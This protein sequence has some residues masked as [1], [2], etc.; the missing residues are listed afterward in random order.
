MNLL[1]VCSAKQKTAWSF[2]CK[3][4]LSWAW[5]RMDW[6]KEPKKLSNTSILGLSVL[7]A[8]IRPNEFNIGEM[9]DAMA[10]GAIGGAALGMIG[11]A[12]NVNTY[13]KQRNWLPGAIKIP[14]MPSPGV[15]GVP[16][17]TVAAPPDKTSVNL[18][19]AVAEEL[20]MNVRFFR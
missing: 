16:E 18:V 4:F 8:V 20:G 7:W 2:R 10:Q 15:P 17:A 1:K 13:G 6:K 11:G 9:T 14:G 3:T 19:S 5:Q 12:S